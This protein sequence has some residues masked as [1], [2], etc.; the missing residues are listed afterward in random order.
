LFI[1]T[2]EFFFLELLILNV[3]LHGSAT[4]Y[5]TIWSQLY[6]TYRT[7]LRQKS[8]LHFM[9]QVYLGSHQWVHFPPWNQL[10][11]KRNPNKPSLKWLVQ[12]G[13]KGKITWFSY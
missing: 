4:L 8:C 12:L 9:Q 6:V 5:Y 7:L 1:F 2:F 3:H 13:V 11:E 10:W